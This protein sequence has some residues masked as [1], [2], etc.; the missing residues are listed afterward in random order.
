[1]GLTYSV[2]LYSMKVD[3][4]SAV[5]VFKQ[6]NDCANVKKENWWLFIS[7]IECVTQLCILYANSNLYMHVPITKQ[8][9][10]Q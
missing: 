3:G 6:Y 7:K 9:G 10:D 2:M 1:M 8:K 4:H 5:G